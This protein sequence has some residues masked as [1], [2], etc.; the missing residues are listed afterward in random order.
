MRTEAYVNRL[1][2][3]TKQENPDVRKIARML[4]LTLDKVSETPAG[5][6]ALR[7]V[8]TRMF[9]DTLRKM[10]NPDRVEVRDTMKEVKATEA[11]AAK[12]KKF[13]P[14]KRPVLPIEEKRRFRHFRM[15]Q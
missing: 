7:L 14:I 9:K 5:D 13:T 8:Q 3:A 11:V 4:E 12:A 6:E 15:E 2:L 1:I 10:T